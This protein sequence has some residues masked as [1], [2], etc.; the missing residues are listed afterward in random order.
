MYI[1]PSSAP[2]GFTVQTVTSTSVV[3]TWNELDCLQRNG[4]I[5]GYTIRYVGDSQNITES[6]SDTTRT[7]TVQ[8]LVPFTEYSFSVAAVNTIG[9]GPFTDPFAF[10]VSTSESS[11]WNVNKYT[12]AL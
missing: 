2:Q 6:F 1:A 4:D 3:L 10:T 5:T 7:Y 8:G 12:N 11:K 9:A